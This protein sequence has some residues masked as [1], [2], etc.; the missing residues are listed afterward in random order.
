[1]GLPTTCT[2]LSF[3]WK[4]T[5]L[6]EEFKPRDG[7]VSITFKK[8]WR[9]IRLI[10]KENGVIYTKEALEDLKLKKKKKKKK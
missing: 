9:P 10:Q 7:F 1:M 8:D 3:D 2:F 4:G 6:Y 5:A